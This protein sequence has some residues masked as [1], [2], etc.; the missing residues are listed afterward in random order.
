MYVCMFVCKYVSLKLTYLKTQSYSNC[1][2][3]KNVIS[4]PSDNLNIFTMSKNELYVF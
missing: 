4:K 2:L 1:G 3:S